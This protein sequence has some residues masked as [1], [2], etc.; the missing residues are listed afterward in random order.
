MYDWMDGWW[1]QTNGPSE[2]HSQFVRIIAELRQIAQENR[3]TVE[4][5]NL[6]DCVLRLVE[7]IN[8]LTVPVVGQQLCDPAQALANRM[9]ELTFEAP[10]A[11]VMLELFGI[12][13]DFVNEHKR[14]LPRDLNDRSANINLY[15]GQ[16]LGRVNGV[17]IAEA[18][19][20]IQA[21]AA[22]QAMAGLYKKLARRE[23]WRFLRYR[24]FAVLTTLVAFGIAA[25]VAYHANK[26]VW[27]VE[28]ARLGTA[29][30]L[31]GLAYYLSQ[32]AKEHRTTQQ[33]AE[34]WSILLEVLRDFV[35]DLPEDLRNDVR[36]KVADQ[37][38][39]RPLDLQPGPSPA[40]EATEMLTDIMDQLTKLISAARGGAAGG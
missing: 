28:L 23:D 33:R 40:K 39:Q 24:A 32:Q 17:A 6:P 25:V 26:L 35:G 20:G 19:R 7:A 5:E 38:F 11:P 30:P 4:Y 36:V 27:T 9:A 16:A 8:Q 10:L 37:L 1:D 3:A 14:L 13:S 22:G 2:L 34:T 31:L 18:R 21:K 29:V 15:L 12:V